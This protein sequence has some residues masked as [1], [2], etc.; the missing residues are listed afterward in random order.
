[1]SRAYFK[2]REFVVPIGENRVLFHFDLETMQKERHISISRRHCN[3]EYEVTL[4]RQ[5]RCHADVEE[6][7][8]E[9]RPGQCLIVPPGRYHIL[10]AQPGD[11]DRFCFRFV[12]LE[13]A[14]AHK[15]A[16]NLRQEALCSFPEGVDRLCAMILEIDR[17]GT[18]GWNELC[19]CLLKVLLMQIF[20]LL[21]LEWIG[22]SVP[23]REVN[24]LL[25]IERYIEE[26]MAQEPTLGELA[27]LMG[28]SP[29]QLVRVLQE[30]LG[31]TFR[32]KLLRA[33]MDRAAWL[34]RTTD[35]PLEV[36]IGEVGYASASAFYQVFRKAFSMTPMK[37]REK[38]RPVLESDKC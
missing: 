5:G 35:M 11:F 21:K 38:Y 22:R 17:A 36:I 31:M 29:R 37:Y 28:M 13:G 15:L 8:Y 27:V 16:G 33:R 25:T 18:T 32:Q 14:L 24:R 9:L 23:R 20:N 2:E 19:S 4:I 1:M 30:Q 6:S 7:H 34:L 10:R 12:V 26:N 3:V